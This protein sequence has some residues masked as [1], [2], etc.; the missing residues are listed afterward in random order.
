MQ[1]RP[2]D[3]KKQWDDFLL[4]HAPRSG[5][6]LHAWEWNGQA[7]RFGVFDGD[8]L[9][10]IASVDEMP[11]PLGMHYGFCQRGPVCADEH[12][13]PQVLDGLAD[14]FRG[15]L[16]LRIEPP[17]SNASLLGARAQKTV[18]ASPAHTL[19][20]PLLSSEEKILEQMH[21]K[22]R[23]NIRLAE[24]KGVMVE[25]GGKSIDEAWPIFEATAARDRFRLHT[26]AH[27]ERLLRI[28]FVS[29]AI[30]RMDGKP[31][32]ANIMVD[33]A[34]TR[35]YLH[36]ASSDEARNVMA[37]HALHWKLIQDANAKGLAHYDWWGI[38]ASDDLHDPWAG[39]TRFKKGFGG[40]DVA[41][42]G[43]FDL[44]LEPVRYRLYTTLR[45]AMRRLRH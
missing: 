26:R 33:F 10:A 28:P 15:D 44:I 37:P 34:G 1:V 25:I 3:D 13:L 23:Y 43:T 27:Y 7:K 18:S 2:I 39:I 42:P 36:G 9:R 32:A 21:P 30:A 6:F 20:L 38:A 41:Y 8:A 19:I 40:E 45:N 11:L 14:A 22:T 12:E 31:L 16:F 29:L 4:A 17:I 35:T 5:A 24:R